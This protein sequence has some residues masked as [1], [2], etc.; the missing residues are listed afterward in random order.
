MKKTILFIV[1]M[2]AVTTL[3]AQT[4]YDNIEPFDVH[5]K[6]WAQVELNGNSVLS[7]KTASRL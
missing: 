2:F 7:T 6:G 3:E 4:G 5:L 1:T